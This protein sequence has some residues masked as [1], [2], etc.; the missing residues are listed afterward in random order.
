MT[1]IA[2]DSLLELAAV[3]E[4]QPECAGDTVPKFTGWAIQVCVHLQ[5]LDFFCVAPGRGQVTVDIVDLL[6]CNAAPG[7]GSSNTPS[8]SF[9]FEAVIDTPFLC[10][11]QVTTAARIS[12]YNRAARGCAKRV[13]Y[14]TQSYSKV[15]RAY[16]A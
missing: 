8:Y 9:G 15:A 11:P 1:F 7:D 6:G 12:A 14:S 13:S 16:R 5:I 2:P 4:L 10:P 3:I